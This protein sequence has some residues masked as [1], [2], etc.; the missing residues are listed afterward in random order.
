MVFARG[1]GVVGCD[2]S[3]SLPIFP[4]VSYDPI[5]DSVCK[6]VGLGTRKSDQSF[7]VCMDPNTAEATKLALSCPPPFPP[8]GVV[9]A[10]WPAVGFVA[11][12][13]LGALGME[14]SAL[15]SFSAWTISFGIE[16]KMDLLLEEVA[17]RPLAA[18]GS[19]AAFTGRTLK[20]KAF[21]SADLRRRAV[22]GV[23]GS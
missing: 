3:E 8:G 1:V 10:D 4:L 21:P 20:S 12:N 5:A 14:K 6:V 2:S 9:L 11:V 7:L 17:G 23:E 15:S 18:G 22:L 19:I 13:F 16:S